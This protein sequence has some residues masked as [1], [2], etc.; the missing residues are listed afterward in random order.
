MDRR[1]FVATLAGGLLV[2][3]LAMEARSAVVP[4]IGYL[5]TR[6]PED[7]AYLLAAFHRGLNEGG[8]VEGKN[9]TV[10][11]RWAFGHYD[12]LPTLAAELVRR[13]VAVLISTGGEP[14]A[15]AAKAA[16]STIPIVF[17]VGSDPVKTGLVA[18][19]NR[20]GGNATGINILTAA[21]E[22]K[23][24]GVLHELLPRAGTIGLLMN[25][26]FVLAERLQKDVEAGARV[27]GLQIQ[28]LPTLT[29]DDVDAA[30]D[31]I[32]HRRI[33]ALMV[34]PDPFFDIRRE[35]LVALA[36]RHMVPTMYHLREYALAGGLMSYGIDLPDAYRQV[37]IYASRVLKGTKPS[38][39]P[40][41]QPTK[42]ELVINLK[43]AKALGLTIP[44]SLLLRADQVIE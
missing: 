23:R 13:P 15:L 3:P 17:A 9:V 25:P 34:L 18:S 2:A 43:T 21:L 6:S 22:A 38:D 40:V 14:A 37:G 19:Y 4:V 26:G 39:L 20:P 10:E 8:F 32:T 29:D 42:F 7:S 27:L 16:T 5:S 11:Y 35:K 44:P 1:T 33:T 31:T 12:R 30:F 24:L 28:P 41:E 36:A